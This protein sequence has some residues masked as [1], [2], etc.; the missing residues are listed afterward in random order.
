M[1]VQTSLGR[2]PRSIPLGLT[3]AR[4]GTGGITGLSPTVAVRRVSD[5][6]Y[7]DWNDDTYK[8][9]GWVAKNAT[10]IDLGAGRYEYT[11]S[12]TSTA[13]TVLAVEY[14]CADVGYAIETTD[15]V[16]VVAALDDLATSVDLALVATDA[17]TAAAG[18]STLA[19]D[20]AS[21][22][23]AVGLCATSVDLALVAT[24]VSGVGSDVADLVGDVAN[25]NTSVAA[26][27]ASVWAETS[28]LTLLERTELLY[29]LARNRLEQYAGDPGS[30]VLF[31]DDATTPL[32]TWELRSA[33]GGGVT[34]ISGSPARRGAA[35]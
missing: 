5:G 30:L 11:L 28:A 23:T 7:L 6:Y 35:T 18:V 15:I 31:D 17:A 29:K 8:A 34:A 22:A 32:V 19:T 14:S 1:I 2:T 9:S 26:V 25:I 24:S 16:Q 27:A 10:L 20:V 4:D 13:G 33:T 3:I 21:V 12:V